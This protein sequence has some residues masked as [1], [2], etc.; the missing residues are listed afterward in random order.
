VRDG[1]ALKSA[2]HPALVL[3]HEVFEKAAHA[4]AAALGMPDLRI[5]VFPQNRSG[6]PDEIEAEKG[7]RAAEA[8]E[9]NLL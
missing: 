1:I 7:A 3:V 8:L 4:Q 9:S 6:E 2:G 5:Y